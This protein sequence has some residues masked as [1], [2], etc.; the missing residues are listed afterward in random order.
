MTEIEKATLS[1][2]LTLSE[3]K[4]Q[5]QDTPGLYRL[6]YKDYPEFMFAM[7]AAYLPSS[8]GYYLRLVAGS[9]VFRSVDKNGYTYKNGELHSYNDLPAVISGDR[10]VWYRDD[11]CHRE[12]DLPAIINGARQEWEPS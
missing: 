5:S 4:T 12:G 1:E 3:K 9:V 11:K 6:N 7:I 8:E 10:K 2:K